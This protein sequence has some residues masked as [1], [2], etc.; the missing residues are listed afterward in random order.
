MHKPLRPTT[1]TMSV[2]KQR[3]LK[4]K[5]GLVLSDLRRQLLY[6]YPFCGTISMS[7]EL[8]PTRDPRITTAACDG[9]HIYFDIDFLSK[10]QPEHQLFVFAHEVWHAVLRHMLRCE[11]RDRNAWNIAADME[12][13]ALLRTDGLSVPPDALL[14][15]QYGF[16][17]DEVHNAETYYDAVIERQQWQKTNSSSSSDSDGKDSSNQ[18]GGNSDGELKGQFDQHI[19]ED[20]NFAGMP[21]PSTEDKYGALEA[22]PDVQ[23][24]VNRADVELIREAA[25]SA[26]QQIER[27]RGELPG[28]LKRLINE[29]I[30]PEM[31]WQEL[32][33]QFVTRCM[34]DKTSWSRPNKRFVASGT[35]LPSRYGEMVK[36]AI[37]LDT[38]GSTS[39]DMVKF[40][41]EL[42]GLVKTF[43]NYELYIIECDT[44][45]GKFE[46]YDE[47]QPLDL[48]NNKWSTTGGGGTT[49]KPIFDKIAEEQ[50][51]IDAAIVF[52]DGWTE[53]FTAEM[54][55]Q[56]PVLWLLTTKDRDENFEFGEKVHFKNA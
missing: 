38:S 28:H 27:S 11:G 46:K 21:C 14:P 41:S 37:G 48:E 34:G 4:H 26:A 20:D 29:L 56:Y 35:Y 39:G 3:E 45:V 15:E 30:K 1:R 33:M 16:N 43:G 49:L 22:D 55:P 52:T 17:R 36:V 42:N 24:N 19:G 6:R 54:A 53:K 50:L 40:L 10:M 5:A 13:N 47:N 51:D 9:K 18:M 32:L 12:V 23:P 25:I 7:L 44:Q 2:E 8:V 31:P